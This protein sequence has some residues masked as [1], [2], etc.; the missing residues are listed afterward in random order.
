MSQQNN[1]QRPRPQIKIRHTV[2]VLPAIIFWA[3]SLAFFVLG[4]SFDDQT[5][6]ML[7]IGIALG[8]AN[9]VVQW[10]GWDTDPEELGGLLYWTW[11]ASYVLG[12]G[13]NM[14]SLI[15]ILQINNTVLEWVVSFALSFIIEV[16]P[17]RLFVLAWRSLNPRPTRQHPFYS[18]NQQHKGNNQV[19][20]NQ[21][22]R[23]KGHQVFGDTPAGMSRGDYLRKLNQEERGRKRPANEQPRVKTEIFDDDEDDEFDI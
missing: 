5:G 1:Q 3:V 18:S 4:L 12:I 17:E 19:K 2:A 9:T 16:S 7:Y 8:L 15:N 23:H 10:I 6:Y 22:Q 20:K 21:Q 13:T 11:M 14:V